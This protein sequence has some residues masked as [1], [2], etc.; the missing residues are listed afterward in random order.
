[1]IRAGVGPEQ[2]REWIR[3]ALDDVA[4]AD[5]YVEEDDLF[6]V[7]IEDEIFY[8]VVE[9]A[10]SRESGESTIIAPHIRLKSEFGRNWTGEAVR[11]QS[12]FLAGFVEALED[13]HDATLLHE[14]GDIHPERL[15]QPDREHETE[16][17]DG[18][19]RVKALNPPPRALSSYGSEQS[20]G[21]KAVTPAKAQAK[22]NVRFMKAIFI[23]I[24]LFCMIVLLQVAAL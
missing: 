11:K 21:S 2:A 22:E 1:M 3:S 5:W 24:I 16:Q 10:S 19:T 17:N 6:I 7:G 14:V 20:D 4:V 23:S 12:A 15:R 13:K 18:H 8:G 9:F